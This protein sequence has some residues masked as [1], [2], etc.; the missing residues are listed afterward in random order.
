[1]L[2]GV[3]VPVLALIGLKFAIFKTFMDRKCGSDLVKNIVIWSRNC[4]E[5]PKQMT[6]ITHVAALCD[7]SQFWMFTY[8]IIFLLQQSNMNTRCL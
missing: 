2:R 8:N 6:K 4:Q 1:M 3:Q 5:M 7:Y